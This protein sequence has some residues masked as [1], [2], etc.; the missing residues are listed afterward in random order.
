MKKQILITT[1]IVALFSL[2]GCDAPTGNKDTDNQTNN[3][4]ATAQAIA[5][6]AGITTLASVTK[7][8]NEIGIPFKK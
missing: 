2:S 1:G 6:P 4:A 5:L 8:G 3:L 7:S